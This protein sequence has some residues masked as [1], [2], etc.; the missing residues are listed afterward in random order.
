MP[1][2]F[3]DRERELLRVIVSNLAARHAAAREAS[4][5]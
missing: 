1:H 5:A 4:I 3:F 2:S